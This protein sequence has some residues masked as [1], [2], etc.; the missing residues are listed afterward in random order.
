MQLIKF[1]LINALAYSAIVD[2]VDKVNTGDGPDSVASVNRLLTRFMSSEMHV[3]VAAQEFRVLARAGFPGEDG[4]SPDQQLF[5][6][7]E[8]ESMIKR[9]ELFN[10]P[11]G[12][13]FR[14]CSRICHIPTHSAGHEQFQCWFCNQR[15]TAFM[16][17]TCKV[18]NNIYS[19]NILYNLP[20]YFRCL[21]VYTCLPRIQMK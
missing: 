3:G 16:C 15:R 9:K 19:D 7:S 18:Y 17:R 20:E 2:V 5:D 21:C 6:I 4:A 11:D 1:V 12:K 13:Q 10:T 14:K 8:G